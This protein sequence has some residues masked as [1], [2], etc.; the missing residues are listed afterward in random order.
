[1]LAYGANVLFGAGGDGV[2]VGPD[3]G[4]SVTLRADAP[5]PFDLDFGVVCDF[6]HWPV[7]ENPWRAHMS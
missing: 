1:M 4:E 3:R 6:S 7:L 2:G 5:A